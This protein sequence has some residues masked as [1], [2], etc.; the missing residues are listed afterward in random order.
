MKIEFF[1]ETKVNGKELY[2]TRVNN[3]FVDGSLEFDH[4]KAKVIYDRIV[5]NGGKMVIEEVLESV[6]IEVAE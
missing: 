4:D 3:S 1:K 5:A 2:F 6:E